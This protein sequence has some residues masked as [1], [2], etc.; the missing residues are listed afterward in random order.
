MR[1]EQLDVDVDRADFIGIRAERAG[2]IRNGL[3]RGAK[4][5]MASI[6][7]DTLM[8]DNDRLRALIQGI[9]RIVENPDDRALHRVRDVTD[10]ERLAPYREHPENR[11]RRAGSPGGA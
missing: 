10:K 5:V 6:N 3:G 9:A 1:L 7:M 11:L 4:T 2:I 8:A